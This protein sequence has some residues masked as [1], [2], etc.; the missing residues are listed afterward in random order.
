MPSHTQVN[1][2][3][4]NSIIGV[5]KTMITK[6]FASRNKWKLC[7]RTLFPIYYLLLL[8]GLNQSIR[9]NYSLAYR[10]YSWFVFLLLLF[11]TIRKFNQIGV[12]SNGD[13]ETLEQFF[14]NPLS[15][16]TLC[17]AL[18]MMSG[19]L[20]S[21]LLYTLGGKKLNP[22]KVLCELSI[23]H[24]TAEAE[25]RQFIFNTFLAVFSAGLA[26]LMAL[27]YA[28]AKYGYIMK[29][30]GTPNLS[31]ETIYCVMIDAYALFISRAAISALAILFYQ[32][33]SVIRRSIK[34]LIKE[35]VPEDQ[36]ECPLPESSLKKI[37]DVQIIYQK[38][39]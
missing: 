32:H 9:P 28:L 3:I 21:S 29:S 22:L 5:K 10:F 30:M 34:H 6:V 36:D 18:M 26:F 19:F 33:C 8:L 11:T 12:K 24:R 37:H 27:T 1:F 25:K 23:S 38:N 15:L 35:M 14:A 13:R 4:K 20:A 17:N 2:S 7:D 16:I 39:L 31:T